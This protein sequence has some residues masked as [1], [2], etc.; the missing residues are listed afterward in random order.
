[1]VA[2]GYHRRDRIYFVCTLPRQSYQLYH[3]TEPER[4]RPRP[5]TDEP[6]NQRRKQGERGT[7]VDYEL[8]RFTKPACPPYEEELS[9]AN[10]LTND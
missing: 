6:T 1:M 4:G 10:L 5:S 8:R 3:P 9:A 2:R 7:D